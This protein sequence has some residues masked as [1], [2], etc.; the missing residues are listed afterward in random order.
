MIAKY[1]VIH[2]TLDYPTQRELIELCTSWAHGKILLLHLNMPFKE[3]RPCTICYRHQHFLHVK[4]DHK[5]PKNEKNIKNYK[6][7]HKKPLNN[8]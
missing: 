7:F 4:M 8:I 2:D 1:V 6:K 3:D 5:N